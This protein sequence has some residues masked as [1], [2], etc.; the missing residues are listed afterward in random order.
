MVCKAHQEYPDLLPE[1]FDSCLFIYLYGSGVG[2]ATNC[3]ISPVAASS[4]GCQK[5]VRH[6][7]VQKERL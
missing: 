7:H 4:L 5:Y 3:S 1:R 2:F 6:C